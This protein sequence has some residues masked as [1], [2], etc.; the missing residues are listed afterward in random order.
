MNKRRLEDSG[1]ANVLRQ[2][3]KEDPYLKQKAAQRTFALLM[4]AQRNISNLKDKPTNEPSYNYF[5]NDDNQPSKTL[6]C[7]K[8]SNS[9]VYGRCSFCENVLCQNCIQ[10]CN[11]CQQC[12]CSTC[13]IIDYSLSSDQIFCLSCKQG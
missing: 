4:E 2:K 8:C 1:F 6:T 11:T 12:Y 5:N 10:Q 9:F 3:Q 7:Y 13:S